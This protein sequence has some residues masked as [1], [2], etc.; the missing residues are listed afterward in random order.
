MP[1]LLTEKWNR[2]PGVIRGAIWMVLAS[3]AFTGLGIG[4]RLASNDINVLEVVF[5]RNIINLLLMLPILMHIG[6]GNMRTTRLGTHMIRAASGVIAM[7]LW[8]TAVSILPLAE[9]T[10]LGFTAPLFATFA[11]RPSVT[12][13]RATA[14]PIGQASATGHRHVGPRSSRRIDISGAEM[15]T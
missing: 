8:F 6:W 13:P 3:A 11:F 1:S 12:R 9:A 10:A 14:R 7:F 15:A 5:F 4:I 2:T